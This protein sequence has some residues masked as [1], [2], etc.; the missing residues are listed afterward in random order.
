MNKYYVSIP[1]VGQ[2]TF[3]VTASSKEEAEQIAFDMD[4]EEAD[5]EYELCEKIVNGNVFYGRLNEVE[6]VEEDRHRGR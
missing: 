1:L 3:E 4:V 6:T 5:V 2:A